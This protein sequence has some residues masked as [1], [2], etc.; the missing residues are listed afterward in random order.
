MV[1]GVPGQLG[2]LAVRRVIVE[3]KRGHEYVII[4]I[5][6]SD[7]QHIPSWKWSSGKNMQ[8]FNDSQVRISE[9]PFLGVSSIFPIQNIKKRFQ[10]AK[11]VVGMS[12]LAVSVRSP[13]HKD[14]AYQCYYTTSQGQKIEVCRFKASYK[15]SPKNKGKGHG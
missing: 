10:R 5:K 15:A 9:R 4:L 7:Q 6:T 1:C 8:H 11:S 14:F 13:C 3:S 12:Y 2:H